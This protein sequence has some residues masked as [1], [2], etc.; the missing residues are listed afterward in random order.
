M[1]KSIIYILFVVSA[2]TL[3]SCAKPGD[4]DELQDQLDQLD[5]KLTQLEQSQQAD[6]LTQIAALQSQINTLASNNDG[7]TSDYEALLASLTSL[8]EEI[9]AGESV[10]YGNVLTDA[11]FAMVL[12]ESA[13]VITG[14]VIVK[15]QGNVDA[16]TS[17]K[18]IGGNLELRG[19]N[20]ITLPALENI[21]K[22]FIIEG[23]NDADASVSLPMI[24]TVGAD[25]VI[26]D[27]NGITSITTPELVLINGDLELDT[28]SMLASVSMEKLDLIVGSLEIYEMNPDTYE[29]GN[30]VSL[31][32]SSTNVDGNVT[33]RYLGEGSELILGEVKGDFLGEGNGFSKIEI[34]NATFDG[35]ITIQ[36][37]ASLAVISFPNMTKVN[38][39]INVLWNVGGGFIGGASSS[40]T[41][42]SCFDNLTE[43]GGNIDV[44]GNIFTEFNAFNKVVTVAGGS[45]KLEENG[46]E[47]TLVNVFNLL[48]GTGTYSSMNINVIEK[49]EW[50]TGFEK[51]TK[52]NSVQVSIVRTQDA[53]WNQGEV[54]KLDGFN[55]LEEVQVLN[56]DIQD[57]TEVNAFPVLSKLT[58]YGEYLKIA[59]PNDTS[60]TLCSMSDLLTRIKNGEFDNQWSTDVKATFWDAWNWQELDRDV[61]ID[62][63]LSG[64][65]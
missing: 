5:D 32:L 35:S 58:K 23:V 1:K 6:L 43:V 59:M 13:T 4:I 8:E 54:A 16:L 22:N 55:L 33:S 14:N 29:N 17:V 45:I 10:Y 46:N 20:S 56:L 9:A 38:G 41:D 31:N 25:F 62:Q 21:A 2:L 39:D 57:A 27:N 19:G 53:N 61:A 50:F 7:L 11:D 28:N 60:V 48:E 26:N 42:L 52:A 63:L 49:T 34:L 3:G 30:L 18:M 15:T 44:S 37:N 64:C 36:N 51:I 12:S 40:L 47:K 24:T 65:I